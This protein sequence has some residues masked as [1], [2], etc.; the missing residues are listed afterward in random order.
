MSKILTP[1]KKVAAMAALTLGGAFTASAHI[2]AEQEAMLR[3][4]K[5]FILRMA[6]PDGTMGPCCSERDAYINPPEERKP[7]G[8]YVITIST[9]NEGKR[10]PK[11][12]KIT[13]PP[14]KVLSGKFAADFCKAQAAEGSTTCKAPPVGVAWVNPTSYNGEPYVYCYWP[15]PRMTL[16]Q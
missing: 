11:P 8:T 13:I 6:R 5:D 2:P 3:D 7:D 9:D 1:M 12:M 15:K 4:Y 10:L 16:G 14:E